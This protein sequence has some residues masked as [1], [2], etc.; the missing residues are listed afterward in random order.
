MECFNLGNRLK[1]SEIF[2]LTKTL[3]PF[4]AE[5]YFLPWHF[6][7]IETQ[8]E[9]SIKKLVDNNLLNIKDNEIKR[10]D[11]NSEEFIECQALGRIAQKSIDRFYI[12]MLQLWRNEKSH[13]SINELKKKCRKISKK[14]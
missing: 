10:P 12:L 8:I 7:E 1:K 6:E 9:K 11:V 14:S 4:F 5:E 13:I 3:Y 2:D